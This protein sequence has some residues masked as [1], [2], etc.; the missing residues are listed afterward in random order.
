[1]L[2]GISSLTASQ[3]VRGQL[4]SNSSQSDN[5]ASAGWKYVTVTEG[6]T[7]YTYIVIGKNMKILIGKSSAKEDDTDKKGAGDKNEDSTTSAKPN[8]GLQTA[9]ATKQTAEKAN[10]LNDC[11]MLGLT[12]YYQK[13]M[14][15]TMEI[16]ENQLGCDKADLTSDRVL[17]TSED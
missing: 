15:E 13:K 4:E 3:A 2:S 10:F 7:I 8:A 5:S 14:R 17:T 11:R 12:G 1:M 9:A 16:M 6:D